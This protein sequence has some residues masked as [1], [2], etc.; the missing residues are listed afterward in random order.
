MAI[1]HAFT[2]RGRAYQCV[3]FDLVVVGARGLLVGSP[4]LHVEVLGNLCVGR[5]V[6]SSLTAQTRRTTGVH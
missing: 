1:L 6:S 2:V 3:R 4:I 5:S